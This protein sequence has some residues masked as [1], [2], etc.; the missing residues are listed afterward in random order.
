MD[1]YKDAAIWIERV[2]TDVLRRQAEALAKRR[3]AGE[4]LPLYGVP[5]AVKD[6]IDVGGL[7]TTAG[8]PA[9]SYT[10]EKSAPVVTRMQNAGALLIGKTNLDQFATGLAGDRSP[11]GAC[12]NIFNKDYIAGGSSSGS[13]LAVAAGLVSFAL[14][15]DTAGSGRV[16]AAFNNIVGLKPTPG[17]LPTEGVV[18]A[19]RSLDCVSIFALTADDA[20]RVCAVAAGQPCSERPAEPT[21]NAE[22]PSFTFA[23]PR[24]EDL[25]FYGDGDQ[26]ALFKQSLERLTEIGGQA[27]AV[28]FRPLQQVGALLYEGPWLAERLAG[29]EDFLKHH[30]DDVYPITREILQ[31]GGRF[32]GVDVFRAQARLAQLRDECAKV[33]TQAEVLVVPTMPSL[34]TLAEVQADSGGWS[35]RLGYYTNYVNLLGW[36]ALAMPAGFTPRGL[37][38]G[39][40]LIG[41]AGSDW[42]LTELG[43][44]WQRRWRL[45][46]GATK[47]H[48][49]ERRSNS[50]EEAPAPVCPGWVRVAVAGAHL[51]GQPWHPGLRSLGAR[52]VR[53]VLTAPRYRFV[54]LLDIDPPRPGLIRDDSRAGAVAVETYDLNYEAFGKLVASVAPPLAIGTIELADGER[55]K[56]FLCESW[57]GAQARDIT[58]FGGWLAFLRHNQP[59]ASPSAGAGKP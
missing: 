15:T 28:D 10:P 43:I 11:Y 14:G 46:L 42:R 51:R 47:H 55:V 22:V 26:S 1:R 58:D 38:G 56:G 23:V 37:P 12:R 30:A 39:I 21:A 8:C 27:R 57:A 35:R 49:P 19:A 13:A 5:F 17:L 44:A 53:S 48:L 20:R 32:S 41:P 34:P 59:T 50:R 54:G 36:A 4:K 3:A 25:E 31:R 52:F 6:N 16:P 45:P 29:L 2:P 40:T 18:P 9:F 24:E 7:P 33:F